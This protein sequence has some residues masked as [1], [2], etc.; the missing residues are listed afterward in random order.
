[1][2]DSA[3]GE[4]SDEL[5]SYILRL[6]PLKTEPPLPE[7]VSEIGGCGEFEFRRP[8]LCPLGISRA[9]LLG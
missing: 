3:A 8:A 2:Q 4:L 9:A 5:V 6:L 1:M 7:L